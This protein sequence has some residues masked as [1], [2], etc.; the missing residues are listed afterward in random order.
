MGSRSDGL[1][2]AVVMGSFLML[3]ARFSKA[4]LWNVST[5][6]KMNEG[7]TTQVLGGLQQSWYTLNVCAYTLCSVRPEGLHELHGRGSGI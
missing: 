2:S 3:I 7:C 5:A 6:V 4:F 1:G